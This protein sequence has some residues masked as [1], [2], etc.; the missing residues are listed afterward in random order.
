MSRFIPD[1]H[2]PLDGWC[3]YH[4]CIHDEDRGKDASPSRHNHLDPERGLSSFE[5][6]ARR[7]P[8]SWAIISEAGV[9]DPDFY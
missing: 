3:N 6:W 1:A 7:N 2:D 9:A 8:D 5:R 4:Q